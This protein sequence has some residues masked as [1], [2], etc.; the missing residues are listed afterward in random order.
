MLTAIVL[1][2]SVPNASALPDCTHDNAIAV[3]RIPGEFGNLAAGLVHGQS[4]L[5]ETS[6]D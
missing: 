5:V 3:V 2:C 4:F 1:I 6:L